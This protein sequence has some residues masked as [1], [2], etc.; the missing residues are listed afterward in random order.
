MTSGCEDI[1]Q[2]V[3]RLLIILLCHARHARGEWYA[4]CA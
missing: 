3:C 2:G 4:V 1:H